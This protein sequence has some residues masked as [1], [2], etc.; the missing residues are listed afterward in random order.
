MRQIFTIGYEGAA[1]EDFVE[2]LKLVDVHL[3]LDVRE[4]PMSRRKGFSKTALREALESVGI[5]YRHEK[6]LG[7]PKEI[8]H[9]LR[10][11]WD[12]DTFFEAFEIHLEEQT[13]LLDELADSLTGHIALL[14]FERDH[15]TCHRTPV[16]KALSERTGVRP[17]HLGVQNHAQRQRFQSQ[18][19]DSRQGLST[20]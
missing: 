2:T 20:A 10:E 7:S 4:L 8:R 5:D 12:Y 11:T 15:K 19:T 14:C 16:A 9:Q 6:Q 13:D 3:L 1:L 18:G 17:K